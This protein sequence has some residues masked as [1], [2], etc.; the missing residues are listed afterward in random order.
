MPDGFDPLDIL[1]WLLV[2]DWGELIGL[3]PLA[4]AALVGLAGL[5]LARAWLAYLS[6]RPLLPAIERP[7]SPP[8]PLRRRLERA[9]ALA[10]AGAATVA[11]AVVVLP[12]RVDGLAQ[13]GPDLL[14][15]TGGILLALAGVALA[16]LE[17]ETA[18]AAAQDGSRAPR[19][20]AE[21]I[22]RWLIASRR[23]FA[24][25]VRLLA[26]VPRPVRPLAG[27]LAGG[28][29]ALASFLVANVPAPGR[30]PEAALPPLLGG[31]VLALASAVAAVR[32]WERD[33]AG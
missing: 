31:I 5:G 25:P 29:L 10:T 18:D 24:L 16:V 14:V 1:R 21:L 13:P 6:S 11:V 33:G 28:L 3:L 30:L 8:A 32:A 27:V 12:S 22:G 19:T 15:L 26:Q 23:S 20:A 17:L 7:T 2:P 9:L 4:I